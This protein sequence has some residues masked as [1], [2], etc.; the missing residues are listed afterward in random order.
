MKNRFFVLASALL[1]LALVGCKPADPDQPTITNVTAQDVV[2]SRV[3]ALG[4][5]FTAGFQSGGLL[6]EFQQ[7][8]WP[9]IIA[10]QMGMTMQQPLVAYPG[11]SSTPGQGVLRWDPATGSI[12]PGE[13]YTNPLA[14]LENATLPRPYDNLGVPG[15]DLIDMIQGT[16]AA[17]TGNPFYDLI[18]RNPNFGNTSQLDQVIAS[19]P[20]MVVSLLGGNDV[21]GAAL[22]GEPQVGDGSTPGDNITPQ[23]LFDQR[24]NTII[25]RIQ[26]ETNAVMVM[27]NLPAVTNLPF[28]TILSNPAYSGVFQDFGPLG[29]LPVVFDG[30]FQPVDFNPDPTAVLYLPLVT[31]E[32]DIKH[33]LLPFL[34]AYQSG[35]G[36]PDSAAVAD[37]LIL[38]GQPAPV[39][40]ATAQQLVLGMQQQ[41]LNP[42]GTPVP[43]TMSLTSGEEQIILDA[44]DGFNTSI[45]SAAQ[46]KGVVVADLITPF[47]EILAGGPAGVSGVSAVFVL[48][49]PAAT[50]F[51]LDGF[52]PNDAGSAVIAKA[53]IQAINAALGSQ[54]PVPDPADYAGQYLNPNPGINLDIAIPAAVG[55]TIDL[56]VK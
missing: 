11:I 52:H 27:A 22:G 12:L 5:S 42:T 46:A 7:N 43:Q 29:V 26:A 48:I 1:L 34:T 36:V 30:N 21:L 49:N 20:T 13:P 53:Y 17:N 2:V 41:G 31:E 16:T 35:V 4:A 28:V 19:N 50:M 3:S 54:I 56:F 8:S 37:F 47:N 24:L 25:D 55:R 39:A 33:L 45:I 15:A 18:L 9:N 6:N 10:R 44:T 32:N 38:T 51:S 40:A 23:S 14:L